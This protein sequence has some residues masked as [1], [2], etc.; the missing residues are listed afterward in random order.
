M[1]SIIIYLFASFVL[2][3]PVFPQSESSCKVLKPSISGSYTGN[4]KKGL[5]HG[6]GIGIGIDRYEGMF[7][8]GLPNGTGT[9][10]WSTGEVY[11][12]QWSE[13]KRHGI[14]SY[15]YVANGKDT[16]NDGNW[17]D[18][19]Y[20][21]PVLPKPLVK[22]KE[23]VDRYTFQRKDYFK[24]RIMVNFY[25]NGARNT[26][27]GNLMIS[28]TSGFETSLGPSIGFEDVSL[29]VTIKLM[30]STPNKL[31]TAEVYVKFEFEI[32]EPG[33]WTVDIHN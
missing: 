28:S 19:Q 22:S 17:I 25:Q 18:D 20:A 15:S 31:K 26:A 33:D 8:N 2:L 13:G 29:P 30:Y 32:F 27:V 10:S 14:G 11:T 3:N 9:Y 16:I 7:R 5:A 24:N 23:N 4:C 21:G 12:G 1:K 6:R